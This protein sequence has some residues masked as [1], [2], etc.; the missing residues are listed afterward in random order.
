MFA[1]QCIYAIHTTYI[2]VLHT[3]LEKL[4]RKA[5]IIIIETLRAIFPT[6]S[7]MESKFFALCKQNELKIKRFLCDECNKQDVSVGTTKIFWAFISSGLPGGLHKQLSRSDSI[8]DLW[9]IFAV[10]HNLRVL[11]HLNCTEENFFLINLN[12]RN[13]FL[14][15]SYCAIV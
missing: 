7:R 6:P 11:I 13:F 8:P 1:H 14:K 4:H 12:F 10:L 2:N 15:H 5:S 9:E 3:I